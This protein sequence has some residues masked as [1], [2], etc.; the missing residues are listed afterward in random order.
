MLILKSTVSAMKNSLSELISR[1]HTAEENISELE[2]LST[3]IIQIATQRELEE[4]A[5]R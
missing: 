5:G 3:E 2:E 1:L 4:K